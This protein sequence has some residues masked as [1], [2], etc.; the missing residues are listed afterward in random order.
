MKFRVYFALLMSG[1]LSLLMSAWITFLNI[2]LQVHF[3][4][5]WMTAWSLAWPV[6]GIVAFVFAPTVQKISQRLAQRF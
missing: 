1:V 4:S 5:S 2:G 6:A 3:F